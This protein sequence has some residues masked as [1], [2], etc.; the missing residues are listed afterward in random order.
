[1]SRGDGLVH[2]TIGGYTNFRC[3][4]DECRMA[5]RD[6]SRE[7]RKRNPEL[8]REIQNKC[9][10]T[11][12]RKASTKAWR[13]RNREHIRDLERA[14]LYGLQRP[15]WEEMVDRQGG[16]CAICYRPNADGRALHV[17][18]DHATGR[19]R[20]LL[21]GGCNAALGLLGDSTEML[22]RSLDYLGDGA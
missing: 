2:G 4:C 13:D 11:P 8:A 9:S 5:C 15:E 20:G 7:W 1:M 21:C 16:K 17:D 6:Y 10:H 3:R 14:R 12:S 19:V 18:H 22:Q